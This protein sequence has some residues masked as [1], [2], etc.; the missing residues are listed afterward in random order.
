MRIGK[1]KTPTRARAKHSRP[2]PPKNTLNC[3][4]GN[5]RCVTNATKPINRRWCGAVRRHAKISETESLGEKSHSDS[6]IFLGHPDQSS[7][8]GDLRAKSIGNVERLA[9][10]FDAPRRECPV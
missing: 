4:F 9:Q 3:F 10:Y 8:G 5:V 6:T 1:K 7:P 2:N